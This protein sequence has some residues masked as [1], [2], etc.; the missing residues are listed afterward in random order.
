M[1]IA[2]ILGD[3]MA[4]WPID[5]LG[6]RTPLEAAN[7]PV[8]D[9]LASQ[10][11]F[12]LVKTVPDG[13][14]P[15]SDTANLAVF[16]YDPRRYYTGRSPLEAYSLGI[17]MADDD[18]A[19][20][21]NL[22]TL[23]RESDISNA[24]MIDYSAGEISTEEARELVRFLDARL[25]QDGIRLYSGL[26]YRHCLILNH[27]ETGVELTPPHD[28]T[29]KSVSGRLPQGTN[30]DLLNKWMRTAYELLEEHPVNIARKKAGKNP[31]NA[32]WFWG[33]GRKPALS[34]FYEKN[35]L[36]G[37]VISAVDLIQGIGLCAGMEI[38]KVEGATGTYQ[39]NFSGK[40]AAAIDAFSRGKDYVYIHIE[41]ADECGHHGQLKE[42]IYSIEQIDE[43]VVKPVL[44]YL[45]AGEEDFAVVVLPDHPTPL[46]IRT[47]TAQPVPYV[48]YRRGDRANRN[49]RYTEEA[50]G[51]TGIYME[52]GFRLIDR[53]TNTQA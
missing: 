31:A 27:A 47:H 22:V 45:E 18:V 33:E 37:A 21:C 3:G 40:A 36:R 1:K 7:H 39:T 24:V 9:R 42:K 26:S 12:G 13:M 17:E 49:V 8:M 30:S 28:F 43:K 4:D 34:S 19:Y 15:G 51:K 5:E 23:S 32:I 16:G 35:G 48:I 38:V 50:A 6:G 46:K 25:S 41:A 11:E 10:G 20:R 52:E 2:V 53:V 14:S 44:S 29:G